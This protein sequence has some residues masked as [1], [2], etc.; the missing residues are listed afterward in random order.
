MFSWRLFFTLVRG[1][2]PNSAYAVMAD[3][4]KTGEEERVFKDDEGERA[5]SWILG[6]GKGTAHKG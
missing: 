5:T 2:G 6:Q 3:D 1:L 4:K